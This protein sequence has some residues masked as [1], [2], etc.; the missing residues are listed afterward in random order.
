MPQHPVATL[1]E[2]E[3]RTLETFVHRGKANERTLN[4]RASC[5]NQPSDGVVQ[6]L[7]QLLMCVR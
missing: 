4:P 3:S 5:S 7:L 6:S 2:E 1:T